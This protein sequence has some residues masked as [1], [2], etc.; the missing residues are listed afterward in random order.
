MGGTMIYLWLAVIAGA[1][2]AYVAMRAAHERPS[3]GLWWLA[4]ASVLMF[5]IPVMFEFIE[6]GSFDELHLLKAMTTMAIPWFAGVGLGMW[7]YF[8][9]IQLRRLLRNLVL[10]MRGQVSAEKQAMRQQYG[11]EVHYKIL[12]SQRHRYDPEERLL[13]QQAV[14]PKN[15]GLVKPSATTAKASTETSLSSTAEPDFNFARPYATLLA[16]MLLH[17]ADELDSAVRDVEL[18]SNKREGSGPVDLTV[19]FKRAM[20]AT[21]QVS[22]TVAYFLSQN[23]EF[24]DKRNLMRK[25]EGRE[26]YLAKMADARRAAESNVDG[27]PIDAT[28]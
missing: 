8:T 18:L 25:T 16:A 6:M 15:E 20:L 4:A 21:L 24:A 13:N 14:H 10:R 17:A 27:A 11:R 26:D 5:C 23:I 22:N 1:L 28:T 2:L 12:N 3:A 9:T 19:R 7:I